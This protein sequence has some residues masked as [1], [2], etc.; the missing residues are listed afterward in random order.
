MRLTLLVT[1]LSIIASPLSDQD[2]VCF[3]MLSGTYIHLANHR[4]DLGDIESYRIEK[5]I[6]SNR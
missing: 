2:V 3:N 6:F 1:C 5:K 4:G